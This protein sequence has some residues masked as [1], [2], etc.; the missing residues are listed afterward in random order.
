MKKH[1]KSQRQLQEI[2]GS[3]VLVWFLAAFLACSVGFGASGGEHHSEGIPKSVVYGAI[4]FAGVL[5]LLYYFTR[6]KV[7]SYFSSRHEKLT[8]AIRE[9]KILKDEADRKHSEYTEKIRNLERE[10]GNILSQ[11]RREGEETK[12]RMIDEAKKLAET[13]EAEAKRAAQNEVEKAKAQL[14]DEVLQQALDGARSVLAKSVAEND[15]RRLQKEFVEK[16]E[17]VQ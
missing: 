4:N 17:A 7:R 8:A 12:A 13:I 11:I 14:Y 1:Y 5:A 16:I 3:P 9:A 2:A 15:Q 10:A 6:D